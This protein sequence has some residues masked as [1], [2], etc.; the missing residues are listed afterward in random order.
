MA[1]WEA[2]EMSFN[3][4]DVRERMREKKKGS[5]RT[6]KLNAS[7]ASKIKTKII[8][9]SSTMKVSLKQNN[10]AL[11]LA[12]NAEKANAQRLTQEKTVLQKEVKQCH[13]QNAV[14]RHRL[15]FL[16]WDFK[17]FKSLFYFSSFQF[18]TNSPSLSRGQT[19][20]MTEDSWADDIADGQLLRLTRMPMRVPISKLRDAEQQASSSTTVQTSSGELQRPASNEP[21]K[22]VPVASKDTLPPQPFVSNHR[23]KKWDVVLK[24]TPAIAK[25]LSLF[26]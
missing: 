5:L 19:S 14:L 7:L 20:S 11:A 10:K 15:S 24:R 18:H 21:P 6:A 13:F 8:N 23:Q 26:L 3:L 1:A 4:S 2:A 22:I 16:V 12:L 9:N 25:S 17:N